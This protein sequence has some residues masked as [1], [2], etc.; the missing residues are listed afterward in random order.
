MFAARG[1]GDPLVGTRIDE[2]R[3]DALLGS[4]GMAR[5]YRAVDVNLDR[6]VAIKIID[7]PYQADTNYAR[8][9]K[10]EAQAI[11]QLEHPH[12]VRLYRYGLSGELF[13]MAMQFIRGVN[14]SEL[15]QIYHANGATVTPAEAARVIR[16]VGDALDYSHSMGVIHRD[17]KSSNII[18]NQQGRAVLVDFGLAMLADQSATAD[19]FGSPHYLAPEQAMPNGRITP[20]TDLYSLGVILYEMLT[21]QRPFSGLDPYSLAQ[22]HIHEEPPAPTAIRPE[23]SPAV[24]KVMLKALSKSPRGRYQSGQALADA[25]ELALLEEPFPTGTNT[26]QLSALDGPPQKLADL[27]RQRM[28]VGAVSTA[29]ASE[30]APKV[31]AASAASAA[32]AGLVPEPSIPT[33]TK[34]SWDE[35]QRRATVPGAVVPP[36]ASAP[37]RRR[38]ALASPVII[39]LLA[40]LL[41]CLGASVLAAANNLRRAS[42]GSEP[43]AAAAAAVILGGGEPLTDTPPGVAVVPPATDVIPNTGV[44]VTGAAPN[45]PGSGPDGAAATATSQVLVP[46][47]TQTAGLQP[48][49]V[50]TTPTSAQPG[51]N[52]PG[53]NPPTATTAPPR[54]TLTNPPPATRTSAPPAQPTASRTPVPPTATFPPPATDTSVPPTPTDPPPPT[55]TVEQPVLPDP[56]YLVSITRRGEDEGWI[57]ITNTGATSIPLATFRVDSRKGSLSAGSWGAES[58]PPGGC[59]VAIRENRQSAGL[60]PAA[61]CSQA[62]TTAVVDNSNSA[63]FKE[64]ITVSFGGQAAGS[65]GKEQYACGVRLQ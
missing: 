13:Y 51:G 26:L 62:G 50:I 1:K 39:S 61:A 45:L 33:R 15:L 64:E 42:L 34:L 30:A 28:E 2:Y 44:E 12:I 6:T 29:S 4:G 32:L 56:I 11:A 65:C 43:T 41:L 52:P 20:Q 5:V 14:L 22:K 60:P 21:G 47:P 49:F 36:A 3:L 35:Q 9:F 46:A 58:L 19:E 38:N 59:L 17:V 48:T 54:P 18:I 55:A 8:R 31:S 57:V 16:E 23:I 37:R 27:V 10:R 7:T 63:I 24:E 25:L 53:G 40:V